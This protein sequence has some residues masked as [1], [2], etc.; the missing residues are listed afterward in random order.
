MTAIIEVALSI[1]PRGADLRIVRIGG[2]SEVL[3]LSRA[4]VYATLFIAL[5]L[6]FL[7]ARLLSWA[8]VPS[9]G[10]IGLGQL[11]GIA[12]AAIGATLGLWC[13]GAFALMSHLLVL[14]YEEP[15]LRSRFGAE[16]GA[17]CRKVHRWWPRFRAGSGVL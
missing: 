1:I 12:L 6:I 4:V 13:I 2:K 16:Y 17:Y 5:M 3:V 15:H 10:E 8:G 14:L 11:A 7:P 9:P